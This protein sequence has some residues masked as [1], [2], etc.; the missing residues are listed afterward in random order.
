MVFYQRNTVDL[1]SM[2]CYG[3]PGKALK[4][5]EIRDGKYDDHAFPMSYRGPSRENEA[6]NYCW[7]FTP[8]SSHITVN[9]GGIRIDERPV[10]ARTTRSHASHQP[11]SDPAIEH[12]SDREPS[13]LN[14]AQ[15]RDP[16][17]ES[18]EDQHARRRW[19]G[20]QLLQGLRCTAA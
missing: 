15:W 2:F 4:L 13:Q 3:A 12:P 1:R 19:S 6:S 16:L 7:V 18:A 5:L 11:D 9:I 14:F 20:T 10:I 8:P 17:T